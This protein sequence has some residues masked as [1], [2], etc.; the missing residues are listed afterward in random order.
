MKSRSKY[1]FQERE[2]Q[3]ERERDNNQACME[4][5]FVARANKTSTFTERDQ[6]ACVRQT[7]RQTETEIERETHIETERERERAV[8]NV[9]CQI[10]SIRKMRSFPSVREGSMLPDTHF[11]VACFLFR[12]TDC[13]IRFFTIFSK[14]N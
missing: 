6:R 3:R 14:I 1:Y 10:K 9:C 13:A 8:N 4:K 11:T 5:T 2:R 7:D 12:N